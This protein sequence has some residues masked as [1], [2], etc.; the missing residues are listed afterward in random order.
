[1]VTTL[2]KHLHNLAKNIDYALRIHKAKYVLVAS[3]SSG[4]GKSLFLSKCTPVLTQI[5]S[6]KVLI[7][8]CQTERNDLLEKTL[9]PSKSNYQFIT[10]TETAGLDYLHGDDLSF[11]KGLPEDEKASTLLAHFTEMTKDYDV[12]F[13]NMK[14]LKRAEKTT[15][16]VLPI[17]GAILVRSPKSSKEKE[18]YITN[19]LTDR[20]IPII[21]L[22]NN[23]GL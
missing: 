8:D 9:S 7:Y 22:V 5:Y 19:E 6:K 18:R 17:D 20:E 13:I 23:E 15:L 16:P 11:A 2:E 3:D 21:G 12:V 1:M 4:E 10:E 14:T